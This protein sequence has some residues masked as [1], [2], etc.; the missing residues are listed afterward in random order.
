LGK[1]T[2]P[3]I[4]HT[5]KDGDLG[6]NGKQ[7]WLYAYSGGPVAMNEKERESLAY[8]LPAEKSGPGKGNDA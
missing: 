7:M 6:K 1:E 4:K 8:R 5:Q 3:S 2:E